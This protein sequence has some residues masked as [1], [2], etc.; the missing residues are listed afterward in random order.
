MYWIPHMGLPILDKLKAEP[1]IYLT[2]FLV[3]PVRDFGSCVFPPPLEMDYDSVIAKAPPSQYVQDVA[4]FMAS[5]VA[6]SCRSFS[7][8]STIDV[9][10]FLNRSWRVVGC[11]HPMALWSHSLY[12]PDATITLDIRRWHVGNVSGIFFG[13]VSLVES[14]VCTALVINMVNLQL[15]YWVLSV[16]PRSWDWKKIAPWIS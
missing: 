2:V 11:H 5:N 13:G 3:S 12:Q 9:E 15:M 7:G 10:G 14:K 8:V 4:M 16:D 1:E 6:G